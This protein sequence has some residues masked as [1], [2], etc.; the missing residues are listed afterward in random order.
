MNPVQFSHSFENSWNVLIIYVL[1]SS[2]SFNVGN[3]KQGHLAGIYD[4]LNVYSDT[5]T[6]M[7]DKNMV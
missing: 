4:T 5:M 1:A 7:E 2:L 3:D 6:I